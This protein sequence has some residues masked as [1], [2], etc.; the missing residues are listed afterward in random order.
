M[1]S[2]IHVH[3]MLKKSDT[4]TY[5]IRVPPKIRSPRFRAPPPVDTAGAAHQPSRHHRGPIHIRI[6]LVSQHA[7]APPA[8]SHIISRL[9][10]NDKKQHKNSTMPPASG[11]LE[12]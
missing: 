11:F 9:T 5:A 6:I 3:C 1:R 7:H 8:P 10:K 12:H 2:S 4:E